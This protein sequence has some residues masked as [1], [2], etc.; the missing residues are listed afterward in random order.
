MENTPSSKTGYAILSDHRSQLMGIAMLWIMLY[1]TFPLTIPVPLLNS[2]KRNGYCGVDIFIFLSAMGQTLSSLKNPR[3]YTQTVWKR[4]ARI[5]PLYYFI[6]VPFY[7]WKMLTGRIA[8]KSVLFSLTFLGY[9]LNTPDHFNWYIPALLVFYLVQPLVLRAVPKR[10]VWR[11]AVTVCVIV[12]SIALCEIFMRVNCTHLLDFFARIPIFWIGVL[13]G[14]AI[15]EERPLDGKGIFFWAL[16]FVLGALY[17]YCGQ[18]SSYYY[19]CRTYGFILTTVPLCLFLCLLMKKLPIPP[20]L[21]FLD[22]VG[23]CTLELYLINAT[24]FIE[25]D[26]FSALLGL[27]PAAYCLVGLP[28]NLLLGIGLHFLR[29]SLRKRLSGT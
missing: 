10:A 24:W 22:L 15:Y 23:Q 12:V 11:N 4:I 20:L 27:S 7:L 19:L 25:F 21:R 6:T 8:L 3:P 29:T 5:L 1:H 28:I 14:V 9:W 18:F 2:I 16:L 17:I 26:F 13:I